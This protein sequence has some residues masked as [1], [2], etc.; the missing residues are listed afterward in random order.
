MKRLLVV[1]MFLASPLTAKE[2]T[3]LGAPQR[4]SPLKYT[5]S[6]ERFTVMKDSAYAGMNTWT[7]VKS[8]ILSAAVDP[9]IE[10]Y[11]LGLSSN[12]STLLGLDLPLTK[13]IQLEAGA[14]THKAPYMLLGAEL[15][16]GPV[17]VFV[18]SVHNRGGHHRVMGG[19]IV[20]WRNSHSLLFWYPHASSVERPV[21][22]VDVKNALA[23]RSKIKEFGDLMSLDLDLSYKWVADVAHS[24]DNFGYGVGVNV[25]K[26]SAKLSQTPYYE[27][28]NKKLTKYELGFATSL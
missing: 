20:Y 23:L 24:K 26:L 21:G 3:E 2:V 9:K 5:Y 25:W 10:K 8:G 14:E 27:S 17:N 28:T 1:L 4:S 12:L 15:P 16:F 6:Q 19:P 13:H 18:A 22:E 11:R 7:G